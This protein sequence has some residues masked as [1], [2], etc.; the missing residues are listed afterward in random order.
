PALA[1][2][3]TGDTLA[4]LIAGLLTQGLNP[5]DAA[6]AGLWLGCRAADLARAAV[7]T[8]PLIAGDLP[9]YIGQAIREL[10]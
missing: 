3:G 7:G 9:R 10:E 1:A 4:G 2:A 5:A 6:I 8:L